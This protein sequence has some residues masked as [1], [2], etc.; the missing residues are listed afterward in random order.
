MIESMFFNHY[1]MKLEISSSRKKTGKPTNVEKITQHIFKAANGSKGNHKE[2]RKHLK[3]NKNR[4][5]KMHGIRMQAML[6]VKFIAIKITLKKI[7]NQQPKF[8]L[9]GTRKRTN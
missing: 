7:T 1:R 6:R 8:T 3:T 9:K 2:M 5:T 4:D